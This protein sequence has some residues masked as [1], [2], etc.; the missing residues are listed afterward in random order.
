MKLTAAASDES[1]EAREKFALHCL[2]TS[3]DPQGRSEEKRLPLGSKVSFLIGYFPVQC[4]PLTKTCCHR[5]IN[6]IYLVND[7]LLVV[8]H[9]E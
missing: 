2:S 6:H 8:L 7:V 3:S 5:F 9:V 1:L 4:Q